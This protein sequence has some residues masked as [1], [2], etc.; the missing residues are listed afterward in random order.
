MAFIPDAP[1]KLSFVPDTPVPGDIASARAALGPETAPD[2]TGVANAAANASEH[3]PMQDVIDMIRAAPSG[4]LPALKGLVSSLNPAENVVNLTHAVHS[5]ISNP[6]AALTAV[7]NA[8]P[9][10]VGKNVLAPTLV[11]AGINELGGAAASLGDTTGAAAAE[12]ATPAGQLGLR[13]TQGRP[14]ATTLAGPTAAPTLDAQNQAVA[15]TVLGADVGVPHG[16]PITSESLEAARKAPG[17]VLDEGAASLP[18]APLSDA[19]AAKVAAARGPATIT[20][21]T[22]NVAAQIE[23]IEN[24]LLAPGAQFSGAQIRATRNSLSSDANAGMNSADADT[25]AIAKYKRGIIDAL[26][27]HVADTMP[28]NSAISPDMVATA[29]ATLAKN[30]SLQDLIGKGGDINLQQLAKL[31]R[32]NPQLLT[33]NTRTVAEFAHAH[34]EVTGGIS[35]ANRIAPPSLATDLAYVNIVNPRTWIQ[36]LFG[37][38]GRRSLTGGNPLNL[39]EQA[40]VTGTA[41]EFEH[42]PLTLG[43]PPGRAFEPHQPQIATGSPQRDFF[44]TGAAHFDLMD[45][46][47]AGGAPQGAGQG[48]SLADLLSHGVEQGPSPGLSAG[49]MG[50]PAP[51]GVPFTVPPESVGRGPLRS[52][53]QIQEPAPTHMIGLEGEPVETG[54]G[55]GPEIANRHEPSLMELLEG[56]QDHPSVMHQNRSLGVTGSPATA[57]RTTGGV[58]EDL[59]THLENNASGESSASMEAIN[60]TTREQA[61]GQDRFLIDPDG[62]MWPI[63]GVEAADATAPKGSIIVQKGI[64]GSPYTILDRGGLPRAHANGLMNRALAGGHGMTLMDLLGG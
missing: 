48:I 51:E 61:S 15:H 23:G 50:A 13:S 53:R 46:L 9:Q 14:V 29:R 6:G 31:H 24:D 58:P 10:Q 52:G 17:T 27:Q 3:G 56:L 43:P 4:I 21:P 45:E 20:K 57:L 8:T 60:R 34:P 7:K 39:A 64:G 5:L 1:K 30:Y 32:D 63:R 18:T 11:G 41:G 44:G 16:T 35:D 59:M 25:R 47:G 33:G 19:A 42:Q 49:P 26:D 37:A 40:P 28:A 54:M 62:K 22:P 2:T 38:M 36:P 12:A 55:H